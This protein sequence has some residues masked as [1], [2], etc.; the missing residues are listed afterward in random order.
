M[1]IRV[2]DVRAALEHTHGIVSDIA[3]AIGVSRQAL[4]KWLEKHPELMDEIKSS[5][6]ILRDKAASHLVQNIENNDQRAIEYVLD[7]VD[8]EGNWVLPGKRIDV[9]GSL[10]TTSTVIILPA[11]GRDDGDSDE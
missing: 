4:Y 2:T 8:E 1:A 7:R 11:N 5:R 6:R 9:R 10:E 3:L